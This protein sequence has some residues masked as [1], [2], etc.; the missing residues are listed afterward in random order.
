MTITPNWTGIIRSGLTHT[1]HYR[2]NT[3]RSKTQLAHPFQ[4]QLLAKV[5]K[6]SQLLRA[7]QRL[8]RDWVEVYIDKS[9]LRYLV[10]WW[11]GHRDITTKSVPTKA[12]TVP[13]SPEFLP[14]SKLINRSFHNSIMDAKKWPP[15]SS[16]YFSFQYDD[17]RTQGA[18]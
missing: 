14:R 10:Y 13:Y 2:M 17:W 16:N 4:V 3:G 9:Q 18:L 6:W 8:N 15:Q 5:Q 11:R 7:S 1:Y 12:S